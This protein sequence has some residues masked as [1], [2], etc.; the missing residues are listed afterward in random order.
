LIARAKSDFPSW[1]H[2]REQTS[3]TATIWGATCGMCGMWGAYNLVYC[4]II[5]ADQGGRYG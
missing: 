5:V 3:T 1:A 4:G 2:V